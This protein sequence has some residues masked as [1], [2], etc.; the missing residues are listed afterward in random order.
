MAKTAPDQQ[1]LL[2]RH[3]AELDHDTRGLMKRDAYML[4]LQP[5]KFI[6]QEQLAEMGPRLTALVVNLPELAVD[7][8]ETRLDLEGFLLPGEVDADEDL[9]EIW[10]DNDLVEGSQQA[11]LEAIGLGRAYGV[12]GV[13]DDEKTPLITAE[14]P[15]EMTAI[16]SPRTREITSGMKRW[17]EDDRSWWSTLYE[18]NE[19]SFWTRLSGRWV[20]DEKQRIEHGWN[21]TP[22]EQLTNRGRLLRSFGRSEF[23]SIIPIADGI[24]KLCTDMMTSAEYHAMPRRW[25]Y[26]LS[27]EDFVD[28]NG[29]KLTTWEQIA[30]RIWATKKKP[31]EVEVGQFREADLS[32]FHNSIKL[33]A[34]LAQQI[35]ALPPDYINFGGVNPT[36][37]D[38]MRAGEAQLVKRAER[39]Q[40]S[41]GGSWRRLMRIALKVR[42]ADD[43]LLLAAKRMQPIWR[44]AA[45]PTNSQKSDSVQKLV[46]G[47]VLPVEGGW[48]EMGYSK[49]R[50]DRLREQFAAQRAA[51]FGEVIKPDP[52]PVPV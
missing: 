16:R 51:E 52:E 12:V 3:N 49:Q 21:M 48:D 25:A 40:T 1:E 39:K 4:G 45:T 23:E 15:L 24:N 2:R 42:G 26:G 36:S 14:H 47:N 6:N 34:Q 13:G 44:D 35:L 5:L 18:P 31:G 8:F 37:A 32:N 10:E 29:R 28:S 20:E 22:V 43:D 46:G 11:H 38:A 17:R 7:A 33:L 9:W 30:G 41:F 50:K 27:K 19:T